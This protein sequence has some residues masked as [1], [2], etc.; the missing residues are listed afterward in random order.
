[1]VDMNKGFEVSSVCRADLQEHFTK[2]QIAKLTDRDMKWLARKMGDSFCDC[3]YWE[4]LQ[5]GVERLL[6]DK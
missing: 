1:M 6:E 4:A 5:V 3:C 2:K